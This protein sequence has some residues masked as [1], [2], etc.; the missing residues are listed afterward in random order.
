MV[1]NNGKNYINFQRNPSQSFIS[2]ISC[3]INN[4]LHKYLQKSCHFFHPGYNVLYK[5]TKW[6]SMFSDP[7]KEKDIPRT[8]M[9]AAHF[10]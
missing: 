10:P 3:I 7:L 8:Q 4:T 2:N 6:I 1:A 9:I 5:D